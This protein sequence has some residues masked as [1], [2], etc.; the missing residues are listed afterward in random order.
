VPEEQLP[1]ELPAVEGHWTRGKA[2]NPLDHA[3]DWVNTSCPQCHGPAKRD[4]DTMDTFVDS[5]WYFMRFID[6]KNGNMLFSSNL[7]NEWLPVDIYIGGVEHAILHLLYARFISKFIASTPLW[8]SRNHGEP[9]KQVLTQGM[10]HGKTYSDPDTGKFLKPDE[11]DLAASSGPLVAT[12]GKLANV[13]YEKMSK[14]KWNGVDPT[15]CIAQYGADAVRAHMLFQAPVSEVLDW[16]EEKI[17]GIT[18]WLRR[19][20]EFVVLGQTNW[21]EAGSHLRPAETP[22]SYFLRRTQDI[23]DPGKVIEGFVSLKSW[24]ERRP[25]TDPRTIERHTFEKDKELWRVVQSTIGSV[26]KAYSETHSLNTVVSDLMALTNM[27]IETSNRPNDGLDSNYAFYPVF[28]INKFATKALLQMMAP[29]TPAFAEECWA[30]LHCHSQV[31]GWSPL[32]GFPL[33]DTLNLFDIETIPNAHKPPMSRIVRFF[34]L[35]GGLSYGY[36]SD[37]QS[38]QNYSGPSIFSEPFPTQDGTLE[39]LAPHTQKCAVQI[40]GKVKFVIEMPI[41]PETLKGK[42]LEEW[43]LKEILEAEE[44]ATKVPSREKIKKMIVARSGKLVNFVLYK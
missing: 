23:L 11:V 32:P 24:N 21:A 25:G 17:S 42:E 20:Y 28:P 31:R 39:L 34:N 13:S 6:P 1:V 30:I 8:D 38:S 14:S 3:Y 44:G 5:S 2:G 33:A 15:V 29:I 19:I 35:P 12:T 37:L 4:T 26:N 43:V 27:I 9:F 16:D 18:R 41:P 40:N 7:I 36:P 22:K 10:V